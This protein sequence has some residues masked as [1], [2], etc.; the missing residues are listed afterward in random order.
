MLRK[1]IP[2]T[3]I[4]PELNQI[5][6]IEGSNWYVL[7][8][9]M[10]GF[11]YESRFIFIRNNKNVGKFLDNDQELLNKINQGGGKLGKI[12]DEKYLKYNKAEDCMYIDI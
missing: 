5:Y 11:A 7:E 10:F 1:L 4:T 2:I 8:L 9:K 6:R 3:T 12:L